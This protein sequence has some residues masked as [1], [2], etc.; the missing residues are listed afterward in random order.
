MKN[1]DYSKYVT[2]VSDVHTTLEEKVKLVNGKMIVKNQYN[3]SEQVY[4]YVAK[5]GTSEE[6][7]LKLS[8]VPRYT[9]IQDEGQL[10]IP[11]PEMIVES[12]TGK[13]VP[14]KYATTEKGQIFTWPPYDYEDKYYITDTDTVDDKMQTT[15]KV[16][17]E[18]FEIKIDYTDG[19]LLDW[20]GPINKDDDEKPSEEENENPSEHKHKFISK[21]Q[22]TQYFCSDATCLMP[23]K[24][25]Y[26]CISCDAKGTET[27]IVGAALGHLYGEKTVVKEGNCTEA[28]SAYSK[29]TRCGDTLNLDTSKNPAN[30]H[31]KEL[32]QITKEA[33]CA[34]EGTKTYKCSSCNATLRTESIPTT[35]HNSEKIVIT[36]EATC[37]EAA[38]YYYKCL[39]C[40]E[41]GSKTYSYG[42]ALGHSY[43]EFQ[44]TKIATCGETGEQERSCT[45]C[46][47][48]QKQTIAKDTR[49]HVGGE[50]STINK[51]ATC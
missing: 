4:N 48:V 6:D 36:K 35:A 19:T 28:G 12:G 32:E 34:T 46:G 39:K 47:E 24:Y 26:K 16:G 49:N 44:I 5:N 30:H 3:Q 2:Y 11:L 8:Q 40:N 50:V 7:V 43:G 1:A 41:K 33:T 10:G 25:Y 23:A 38:I 20:E 21:V 22:T 14:V 9:I 31:G 17:D 27:F 13:R 37:T 18:E 51:M 42:K 45:R 15:I 29:C